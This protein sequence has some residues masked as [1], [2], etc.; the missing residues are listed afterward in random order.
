MIGEITLMEI[1]SKYKNLKSQIDNDILQK[2]YEQFSFLYINVDALLNQDENDEQSVKSKEINHYFLNYFKKN[3]FLFYHICNNQSQMNIGT[4]S[5]LIDAIICVENYCVILE[6]IKSILFKDIINNLQKEK[7][8]ILNANDDLIKEEISN[9]CSHFQKQ[10]DNNSFVKSTI[11]SIAGF[12]IRRFF[13]PTN[14]FKNS[15]FF[16]FN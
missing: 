14:Y 12:L 16:S 3:K 11:N 7:I 5:R 2:I 4:D 15:S 13:Y 8:S 6:Q 1:P 10:I 9:F